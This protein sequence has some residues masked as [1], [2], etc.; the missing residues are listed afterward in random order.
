MRKIV[1]ISVALLFWQA[2]R[3]EVK[4]IKAIAFEERRIENAMVTI[5]TECLIKVA[6]SFPKHATEPIFTVIGYKNHNL[7]YNCNIGVQ[8]EYY[9]GYNQTAELP[10]GKVV[11]WRK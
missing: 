9:R 2:K 4:N 1:A 7:W 10:N 5:Q 3:I 8:T 6:K 11:W